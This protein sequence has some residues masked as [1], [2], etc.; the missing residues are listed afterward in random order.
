MIR[1]DVETRGLSWTYP[2]HRVFLAQFGL[3]TGEVELLRHPQDAQRIQRLLGTD[4]GYEAW[5]TK[6]DMHHLAS[7]GYVLPPQRQWHDGMVKAH[8]ADERQSAALA[9]R[10]DLLGYPDARGHERELHAWILE[11][12]KRRRKAVKAGESELYVPPNYADVPWEI[13]EPYARDDI[14]QTTYVSD[15]YERVLVNNAEL[16]GLYDLE[17]QVLGALYDVERLG[18]PIDREAAVLF[19][20]ELLDEL[21]RKL[22]RIQELAGDDDFNPNSG[23]Q[24]IEA[25]ERRGAD[26]RFVTNTK[27]GK[28]KTDEENLSAIDD[29]LAEA[30][31]DW[32]ATNKMYG[33]YVRRMLHDDQGDYGVEP[34][35]L[36][37]DDRIHANFRQV[38]ARTGR[39]S[40]SDPNLQNWHRDDLRL[41]YLVRARPGKVLVAADLDAIEMRLFAAFAGDGALLEAVR[42]GEDMHTL[43]ADMVGLEDFKRSGG[44]VESRRQRGKTFNYSM[45]YGAGVRSLRKKFRV[46]QKEAK[47]MIAAYKGGY[48]DGAYQ[49]GAFPEVQGLQDTIAL[50]LQDRGYIKTPWG[51]RHRV[52]VR[53]AYKGTNYLVQGTAADMFKEA[54]VRVHEAG[55]PVIVAN[56]DELVAEVDPSDAEEAAHVIQ[57][58]LTDHPRI[59]KVVP[60]D[61][62]AKIVS[63]WS[64]A[65][66]PSFTPSYMTRGA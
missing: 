64:E 7:A 60:V 4:D 63:R 28:P 26:L 23:A 58:A 15:I 2:D 56:H 6:F 21:D 3:P 8:I 59:T 27:G 18:F 62:E 10:A 34:A 20:A 46:S 55:V 57:E 30:V 42:R 35:Y 39:M 25:L 11:E 65:K 45:A 22:S 47:R 43:A 19:E 37:P 12:R 40:S 16:A 31:L 38:G 48:V 52:D 24:I 36:G 29:E 1:V 61:A 53:D 41:R 5:N 32:R 66:D 50:K 54:L 13:M 33:T 17:M 9:A 14:L 49:Q 51:R 44:A